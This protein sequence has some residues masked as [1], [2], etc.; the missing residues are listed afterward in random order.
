MN[1]PR[2]LGNRRGGPLIC[3]GSVIIITFLAAWSININI[4]SFL[5]SSFLFCILFILNLFI[6]TVQ[7]IS[8]YQECKQYNSWKANP[9]AFEAS[10]KLVNEQQKAAYEQRLAK[11]RRELELE[12]QFAI[13]S[14]KN[15]A[16]W[17]RYYS[18]PCPYCGHYKVRPSKWDDKRMSVAFWG[19]HSQKIGKQYKCDY[20]GSMWN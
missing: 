8:Y 6:F 11:M 20:C 10:Q 12:K 2:L 14:Q 7:I 13:E 1:K 3:S 4:F 15:A 5:F 9:R 19:I 16:P 17:E 18:Y